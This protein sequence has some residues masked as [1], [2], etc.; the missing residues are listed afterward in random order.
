M[1]WPPKI[2]TA[3]YNE[4]PKPF[5][6]W[7]FN[8]KSKLRPELPMVTELLYKYCDQDPEKFDRLNGYLEEAFNAGVKHGKRE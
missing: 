8:A 6:A 3:K 7:Y 5:E 4:R 2:A 1:A